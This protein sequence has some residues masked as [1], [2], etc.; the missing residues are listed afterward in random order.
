MRLQRRLLPYL[1]ELYQ[2]PPCVHGHLSARSIKTNAEA[3]VGRRFI[4]NVDLSDFYHSIHFSRIASILSSS[5]YGIAGPVATAI[6]QLCCL[7]GRLPIG[8]PTSGAISNIVAG[9]LDSRLLRLAKKHRLRYTRYVDDM[10]FSAASSGHLTDALGVDFRGGFVL[11]GEHHLSD[12]FKA[13][14]AEGGFAVNPSKVWCASRQAR[15]QVTGLVTN[16]K[17]NVPIGYFKKTRSMVHSIEKFGPKKANEVFQNHRNKFD[18]EEIISHVHGRLAHIGYIVDY[19]ARYTRLAKRFVKLTGRQLPLPLLDREKATYVIK[20]MPSGVQ[21]T[22]VHI[23]NGYFLTAS[24]TFDNK[25]DSEYGA[26][27]FCPAYYPSPL[28]CKLVSRDLATDAALLRAPAKSTENRPSVQMVV[29]SISVGDTAEGFGYADYDSGGGLNVVTAKMSAMRNLFGKQRP[30]VDKPWPHGM[31]GGPVFDENGLF[32]GIIYSGPKH[33]TNDS[34]L[35]TAFT[36]YNL[37]SGELNEWLENDKAP[38]N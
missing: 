2:A 16:K 10:T 24:H 33:G 3:H 18:S 14:I 30:E 17:A 28:V 29:R 6:A 34:P 4:V 37:F 1:N 15:Q 20:T 21:G 23:G 27:V 9:P 32:L 11:H 36:P 35:G 8:A 25:P 19:D 31:S 12:E 38:S 13:L 7:E 26:S 5:R 22:A